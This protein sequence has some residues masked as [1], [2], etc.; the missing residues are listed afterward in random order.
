MAGSWGRAVLRFQGHHHTASWWLHRGPPYWQHG[1][2][3]I[4]A[5]VTDMLCHWGFKA[6]SPDEQEHGA[7]SQGQTSPL[8]VPVHCFTFFFFLLVVAELWEFRFQILDVT[9][10]G[11]VDTFSLVLYAATTLGSLW[12]TRESS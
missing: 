8:Q 9:D 6:L 11:F 5:T 7:S 12:G 1:R 10:P 4:L 2:V 3:F